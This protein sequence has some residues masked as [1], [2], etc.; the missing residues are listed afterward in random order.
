M[1]FCMVL[2][3][4]A[5][6]GHVKKL[7]PSFFAALRQQIL[8][9]VSLR[10]FRSPVEISMLANSLVKLKLYDRTLCERLAL[11][12]RDRLINGESFHVRELAVV[13]SAFAALN[14][15]DDNLFSQ[16]ADSS[17]QTLTEATPL[18]LARLIMAFSSFLSSS[19]RTSSSSSSSV[20]TS[21]SSLLSGRGKEEERE[22]F[23]G[24][25]TK[26]ELLLEACVPCAREKVRFMS[27]ADLTLAANAVGQAHAL[28]SSPSLRQHVATLLS[29]IRCLSISS[30]ELFTPQQIASMLFSFSR[31]RQ[32]FPVR[33]LIHIVDHI[34]SSFSPSQ[35]IFSRGQLEASSSSTLIEGKHRLHIDTA[36]QVSILYSLSIFLSWRRSSFHP[37]S[38]PSAL[39]SR[40]DEERRSEVRGEKEVKEDTKSRHLRQAV[41]W[42]FM[43][44]LDSIV[45]SCCCAGGAQRVASHEV[46]YLDIKKREKEEEEEQQKQIMKKGV[47]IDRKTYDGRMKGGGIEREEEE[48]Y[49]ESDQTPQKRIERSLRRGGNPSNEELQH[50]LRL[51]GTLANCMP[52]EDS[53]VVKEFLRRVQPA[54][55]CMHRQL[56]S[57]LASQLL[58]F[59][60]ILG[61]EE[62]SDFTLL[63]KEKQKAQ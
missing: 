9:R 24:I 51:F 8:H 55:I 52:V 25:Y 34:T 41:V 36:T 15:S 62:D 11:H 3:A 45:S 39:S 42:L 19:S 18:E 22:D 26:F 16:I 49:D 21:S 1:H 13:A 35:A 20:H 7:Q 58:H 61:V 2:S 46:D 50:L 23:G 28:V 30:I 43:R 4:Y 44:W 10:E 37:L 29:D 53:S 31:W 40:A 63:L 33:D 54:F 59:L 60:S 14:Y 6:S 32:A 47:G 27:P 48:G 38:S 17:L 12:L 5:K 56:H 57:S